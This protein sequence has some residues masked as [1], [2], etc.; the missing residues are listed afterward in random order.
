MDFTEI[1]KEIIIRFGA[2]GLCI[3]ILGVLLY[4]E[5]KEKKE[6]LDKF[7]D[8]E[9]ALAPITTSLQ[10]ML[11]HQNKAINWLQE[12][13]E[14]EMKELKEQLIKIHEEIIRDNK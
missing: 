6:F 7:A 8:T 3:V 11:G 9:K 1:I 10:V 14:K 5:K 4:Q 2:P 12:L 13:V